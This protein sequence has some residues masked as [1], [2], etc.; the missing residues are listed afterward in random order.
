VRLKNYIKS[1]IVANNPSQFGF[2]RMFQT[3]NDN[4]QIEIRIFPA[5][6]SAMEWLT[7]TPSTVH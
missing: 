2:A 3:L 7:A 6:E 1:A 4:P 5:A